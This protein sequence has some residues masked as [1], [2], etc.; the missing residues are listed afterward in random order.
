MS[1]NFGLV[2]I[3]YVPFIDIILQY[4]YVYSSLAT[5]ELIPEHSDKC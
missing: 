1:N 5:Q 3:F 4:V 2:E